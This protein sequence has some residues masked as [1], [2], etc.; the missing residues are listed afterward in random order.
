MLKKIDIKMNEALNVTESPNSEA[1]C[2]YCRDSVSIENEYCCSGCEVVLHQDCCEQLSECPTLGCSVDLPE[3]SQSQ[4]GEQ[5]GTVI[6]DS[7]AHQQEPISNFSNFTV[8]AKTL[9]KLAY[10][11]LPVFYLLTAL[12]CMLLGLGLSE[13][14]Y[15]IYCINVFDGAR[16]TE[17]GSARHYQIINGVIHVSERFLERLHS[18]FLTGGSII[19]FFAGIFLRFVYMAIAA[20][21][22]RVN[23][24]S[25][26]K[27]KIKKNNSKSG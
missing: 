6:G 12:I 5:L 1:R 25:E 23:T 7:Q 20:F 21:G 9:A 26:I 10:Q 18:R 16:I 4:T 19:G 13:L 3:R 15:H 17:G 14:I 11:N 24:V 2:A 22:R 8:G 27:E